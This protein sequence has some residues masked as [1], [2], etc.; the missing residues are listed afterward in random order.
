MKGGRPVLLAGT[1]TRWGSTMR[2]RIAPDVSDQLPGEISPAGVIAARW[3]GELDR[4]ARRRG[5]D[6]LAQIRAQLAQTRADLAHARAEV[7]QLRVERDAALADATLSRDSHAEAMA[8]C[9][10][11]TVKHEA[12]I[13]SLAPALTGMLLG[14]SLRAW[15]EGW[16]AAA[17]T[18]LGK[19]QNPHRRAAAEAAGTGTAP[20]LVLRRD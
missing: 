12:L 14:A 8:G 17:T 13:D 16:D 5:Q 15:D 11:I 1:L 4:S 3:S 18:G 7:G 2:L 9:A 19:I 6:A 20:G 10:E